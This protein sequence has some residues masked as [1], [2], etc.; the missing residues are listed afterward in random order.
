LG[1]RG[2]T[3]TGG[4]GRLVLLRIGVENEKAALTDNCF[5]RQGRLKL[6]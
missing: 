6:Q 3:S 2:F 4:G 1:D 5:L